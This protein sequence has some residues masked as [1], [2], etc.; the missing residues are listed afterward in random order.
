M[1]QSSTT[2]PRIKNCS[3]KFGSL[4]LCDFK[5]DEMLGSKK[6]KTVTCMVITMLS[7]NSLIAENRARISGIGY[8][9]W[10][11]ALRHLS[12]TRAA[13]LQLLVPVIAAGGGV[14]LLSESIT[15]RLILSGILIIGG[16]GLTL[17]AKQQ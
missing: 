14:L 5:K 10:Y 8:V 1:S 13:M 17:K 12:A 9:V 6:G 7:F 15:L 4:V 3:V 11:A 16:V 2:L